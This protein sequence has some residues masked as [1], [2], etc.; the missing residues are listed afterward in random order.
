MIARQTTT[1][2]L[3]KLL[4]IFLSII[5]LATPVIANERQ[6]HPVVKALIQRG[7]KH[8]SKNPG[9]YEGGSE[10]VWFEATIDIKRGT[11]LYGRRQ[12]MDGDWDAFGK[13]YPGESVK[14]VRA[15]KDGKFVWITKDNDVSAGSF[16][17]I[18]SIYLKP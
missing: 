2:F 15:S 10:C 5:L 7:G 11:F 1:N 8:C 6:I 3:M 9:D 12:G 16:D 18:L 4:S 14:V 13:Y 17:R